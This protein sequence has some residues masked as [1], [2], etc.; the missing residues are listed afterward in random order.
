MDCRA[1]RKKSALPSTSLMP[2]STSPDRQ[3]LPLNVL[4]L[5]HRYSDIRISNL[6]SRYV[7]YSVQ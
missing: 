3:G 4:S 2:T 6:M 1:L 5:E 7:N